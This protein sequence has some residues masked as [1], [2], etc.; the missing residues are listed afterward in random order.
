MIQKHILVTY[1]FAMFSLSWQFTIPYFG[2][3]LLLFN[4]K[5]LETEIDDEEVYINGEE[6]SLLSGD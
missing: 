3:Y 4:D 2:F 6:G 1:F 5:V